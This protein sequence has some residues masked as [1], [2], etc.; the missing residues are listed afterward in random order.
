MPLKH[1]T[2][3]V[4]V[5]FLGLAIALSGAVAAFLPPVSVSIL[6]WAAAFALSLIYPLA[7]YPMM[8]ERRADYEFRALHFVPALVLLIWLALDLLVVFKPQWQIMQSFF[9]WSWAL[10]VVVGA[11]VLLV[12]FCLRVIRQRFSRIGLLV[13][14]LLPFLILSQISEKYS[15]E[16]QLA[17]SIWDGEIASTG[18]GQIAQGETSSNLAPSSDGAEEQWRAALRRMEQRRQQLERENASSA[19]MS[20]AALEG[21]MSSSLIAQSSLPASTGTSGTGA[22]D[23]RPVT[24]PPHLPSS[25]FGMEGMALAMAAGYC[26]T[27]QRR[28]IKRRFQ[29]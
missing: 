10:P 6:P 14:V 24:P 17:M 2:E 18:T 5:F 29:A 22:G 19:G 25:G 4:M 3:T 15:W 13:A 16:R 28:M 26:T 21:A 27:V 1:D 20:S 7:L 9:T 12:L 11:F 8:K 23:D